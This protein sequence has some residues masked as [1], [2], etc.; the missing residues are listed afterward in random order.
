M[1]RS[2]TPHCSYSPN[3]IIPVAI[4]EPLTSYRRVN[5]DFVKFLTHGEVTSELLLLLIKLYGL[6]AKHDFENV[7]GKEKLFSESWLIEPNFPHCLK[8]K[9]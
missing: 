3:A 1:R 4:L 9:G 2:Y 5:C 7:I 8:K 6:M